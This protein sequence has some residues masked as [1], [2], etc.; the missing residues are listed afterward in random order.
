MAEW[1]VEDGIGERR[2]VLV[3]DGTIV[4][5]MVERDSDGARAGCIS[6]ARLLPRDT[7]AIR[8]V[9]LASG[10]ETILSGTPP[11]VADGASLTVAITR[12]AIREAEVDKRAM[13]RVADPDAVPGPGPD[14]AARIAATGHPSR[15]V[16]AHA[17]DAF[18]AAGW[19]EWIEV[20]R[21]GQFGFPGGL[22]RLSLTPAMAVIDIDGSLPPFELARAGLAAAAR[23]I[24]ALDIGGSI[25]IDCPTLAGKGERVAAVEAFDAAL[26]PPFERTAINGYG[27][28]QIIRPRL[29]PSLVE[30]A[31]FA[32]DESAALA[33]LRRAE[34][35]RGTGP[36]TLLA[37][38]RVDDWLD[39][40]PALIGELQRRTGRPVALQADAA[41]TIW[42]YDVH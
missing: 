10:E 11:P 40:R 2:A 8:I 33:L 39:A 41:R 9:R 21:G 42:S 12:S 31:R 5:I 4:E 6:E 26:S 20:A 3:A 19:S 16:R 38:P 1:L 22:L 23:M 28:L 18:E 30:R 7:G 24:R 27:L 17:D 15:Q 13:A 14:I 29:R 36:L 25:V 34:R 37:H 35:A 32:A